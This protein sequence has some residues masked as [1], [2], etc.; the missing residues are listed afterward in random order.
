MLFKSGRVAECCEEHLWSYYNN[1]NN[2]NPDKLITTT[3]R[4]LIDNPKG[5]KNKDGLYRWSVPINQPVQYSEKT[6]SVDPYV[7]G[8]I[9]GDGSFRYNLSNK[10]FTFSSTDEELVKAI[11][12]RQGYLTYKKNSKHNCNWSF[13]L[14]NQENHK[15][16][17]VEDILKDYPELW[18]L[19]S[20]NKYIP[21]EF[22]LGSIEQ[23]YDL[24]AGLLDTDGSIDEKGRINF[25]TASKF[26]KNNIIEL[27]ESLGLTCNY[28][29]DARDKYTTGECYSIYIKA[30]KII[31]QKFFKLKRK[32]DIAIA[33][34]NNEKREEK[35]DRDSIIK[36]EATGKFTD[37]TCFYVDNDE[38]LFLMNN[39]ISTHN[40]RSMLG[41][42]CYMS[43]P[44]F[45]DISKNKWVST[46][47]CE[48][49]CFIMSEQKPE[50]IKTM[51]LSFLTG[52][53]EEK[54]LYNKCSASDKEKIE[55]AIDIM[56]KFKD[57]LYIIYMPDPC[58]SKVKNIVRQYNLQKGVQNFFYDY[59]YSSPAMLE[60]YRDLKLAEHVCLRLFTTAIKNLAIELDVF[61]FSATQ[62]NDDAP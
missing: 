30:S 26:L 52:I 19:K 42:A 10:S 11:C 16:V 12:S 58:S 48:K 61:I 54:I 41:D 2:R 55:I 35:R 6:F 23:R 15:N 24:L 1:S 3:L 33:Y 40:T 13:E 37:M 60:E 32:L 21:Q 27:C 31:K 34:A 38:H 62:L 28:R 5:L 51:I 9:L 47:N 4:E 45:F 7:M 59:I 56:E 57:N 36:I 50:E 14:I 25:T 20:E 49:S 46:G 39:Y 44:I 8:L 29:I 53:N 18:Q 17:W 43:Y 22:L